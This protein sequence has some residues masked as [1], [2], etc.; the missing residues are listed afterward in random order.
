MEFRKNVESDISKKR[1][2]LNPSSVKTYVSILFNISKKINPD[3][4]ELSFFE[5]PAPLKEVQKQKNV[6][7]DY[8]QCVK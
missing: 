7:Q 6:W 8:G 3:N 2:N 5:N 1:P 4:T